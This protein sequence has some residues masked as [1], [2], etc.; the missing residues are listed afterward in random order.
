MKE[1]RKILYIVEATLK[2]GAGK[3]AIE[4]IL[5]VQ[6]SAEFTPVVI[7]QLPNDINDFCSKIGIENYSANYARTCS[8]DMK[9]LGRLFFFL[10]RPFLNRFALKKIKKKLD[11]SQICL[12]HSNAISIDF[13]AFLHKKTHI[14]H[15]WHVRD[16]LIFEKKWHSII[17]NLPL[18]AE[19]NSSKII[20]VS[21]SLKNYLIQQGC[22]KNSI[23]A[24]HDGVELLSNEKKEHIS[25]FLKKVL[26]V[27][28]VGLICEMKGQEILIDAII[29]IP[30]EKR[31]FFKFHFYG[32]KDS[33]TMNRI[34]DK[35]TKNKLD[36]IILFH[37]FNSNI[38]SVLV[39]MDIGVQPSHSEGFSRVTAE[40]MAAGLCVIAAEE[41]AICELIQ[42]GKNGLLYEDYNAQELA[43]HLIY[44]L[45]NIKK[46]T[47]YAQNAYN[48][49]WKKYN[50]ENN[51]KKILHVYRKIL[52]IQSKE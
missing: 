45:E 20:T 16:F 21:N 40:Y 47:Y 32:E 38:F 31:S 13:G 30:E 50:F 17:W 18:Y 43:N 9:G 15:I 4:L 51:Y 1:K 49:A 29:R 37:D 5:R 48:D 11:L 2:T 10:I 7:T 26:N 23:I 14:P 22:S 27:V 12:I 41:G 42:N 39:D 35:I 3:C 44:C 36:D 6:N 34:R 8:L 25:P 24:I 52:N 33:K 19:K 28:C 46:M